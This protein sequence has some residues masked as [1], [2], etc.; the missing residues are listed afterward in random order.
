MGSIMRRGQKLYLRYIDSDGTERTRPSSR[1]DYDCRGA[2][3]ARG[4]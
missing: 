4:G 3:D 1:R 2:P